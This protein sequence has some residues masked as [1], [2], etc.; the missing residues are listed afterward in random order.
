MNTPKNDF[1]FNPLITKIKD[2]IDPTAT[3]Q[4]YLEECND[5]YTNF[6]IEKLKEKKSKEPFVTEVHHIFPKS[7]GGPEL[8]WNEIYLSIE[9]HTEA[10][11]L[12]AE[13]YG[14]TPDVLAVRMRLSQSAEARR[15]FLQKSIDTRRVLGITVFDPGFQ[16]RAGKI[17]GSIFS[18][19]KSEKWAEK[20][21][22]SSREA[23]ANTMIWK[24]KSGEILTFP[25]GT[26][27]R[28]QYLARAL[29]QAVP[30]KSNK[31]AEKDAPGALSK[32]MKGTRQSYSGW[33]FVKT[34]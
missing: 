23:F 3:F 7:I 1:D 13:V 24:H 27:E 32:V 33:F 12:R 6:I 34:S 18:E 8:P 4:S 10:H 30:F 29:H 22:P 15:I 20:M 28:P 19:E 14:Q 17:G 26:I 25:P 16:S 11:A 5:S 2:S 9:D 21:N 31:I